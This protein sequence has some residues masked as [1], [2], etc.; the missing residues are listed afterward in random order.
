[1]A[2]EVATPAGYD[3]ATNGLDPAVYGT[4][5]SPAFTGTP[6]R[7]FPFTLDP[8]QAAACACIERGESVLVAAHTSA[9]KTAVAEYAIAAALRAGRTVAYTSPLKALSNQ[10]YRE[11]SEAFGEVGLL[12][13]DVTLAPAAPVTVMT[14]EILRSMLYRGSDGLD[15]LAWIVFDEVHYMQDRER[16][17]VWEEAIIF[18]P[19][20][21]RMV[22]LS[23]T[24]SNA[25][26]FAGWV[27]RLRQA[28]C[29]VIS[30]DTRPTPLQHYAYPLGGRGL[31]L[32]GDE[33]G[34]F[35]ADA[36]A[37]MRADAFG[38]TSEAEAGGGEEKE[39][40][41][42]A[43]RK[44]RK[45]RREAS[46]AGGVGGEAGG[47]PAQP[48]PP[49][50]QKL[51][52]GRPGAAAEVAPNVA[53]IVRLIHDRGLAPAIVFSFS[54]RNCE[55]YAAALLARRGGDR[56]PLPPGKSAPPPDPT[57]EPPAFNTPAESAAVDVVFDQAIAC[58]SPADAGLRAVTALRPLLRAGV[59]VHHSGLLP[60]LKE[61]VELL[62][63]EG[64]VKVLFATETFAMGLNMPAKTVVFTEVSGGGRG[65]ER[66]GAAPLFPFHLSF[67][68]P[69]LCSTLS[70]RSPPPSLSHQARKWDGECTRLMTSGEYIQ[71]S[72]RAGRRGKDDRGVC[73][74]LADSGLGAAAAAAMLRGGGGPLQSSFRL[75]FYTLLNLARRAEGSGRDAEYVVARSFRQYQHEVAQPLLAADKEAVERERARVVAGVVGEGT[76]APAAAVALALEAAALRRTLRDALLAPHRVAALLT[77]GRL[78]RVR[79]GAADWGWGLVVSVSREAGGPAPPGAAGAP[80]GA[81]PPATPLPPDPASAFTVD[82]LL[83]CAPGSANTGAPPSPASPGDPAAELHAVPVP[84]P[85]VE[86]AG[87]LRVGLPADLRPPA[88]R[89]AALATLACLEA[90]YAATPGGIPTLDPVADAGVDDP[91]VLQAAARLREVEARLRAAAAG[92]ASLA[93]ALAGPALASS[94]AR[95]A[96]LASRSA[97]LT[98]AMRDS[99]LKL[100][101]AEARR[102]LGVLRA[103]GHLEASGE[104]EEEGGGGGGGPPALS[105][106]LTLKGRAA[107]EIDAADELLAAE[108]MFN[109]VF[110]GL[111][112]PRLA[113]LASCLVPV[114]KSTAPVELAAALAGPLADLQAA[115]RRIGSAQVDARIP[116]A[117]APD[118]YVAGF[119]PT[120]MDAV[121]AWA[122][123]ATF[124]QVSEDGGGG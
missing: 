35:R 23:A 8:F 18:A 85:L 72:G 58:L 61:L 15:D 111:D 17:V 11:L 79:D 89:A 64:L 1:M 84:L 114:E 51:A 92:D 25:S 50:Q 38:I 41:G 54:R 3:D 71:M 101:R 31:Y 80:P 112:P 26:E 120:L 47:S 46:P 48:A 99:Q 4:L 10:K 75:S 90:R 95:A 36:W 74:L 44:G 102:R 14:T 67:T 76:G 97:A 73:I 29:H 32:V 65:N 83:R 43:D 124:Q 16:G 78:V 100:Y 57:S 49:Q 77:P 39:E 66:A 6:A 82:T 30:T 2:H 68:N 121:Y 62:F 37:K 45:R 40:E 88:P 116:D 56:R 7:T 52:P 123:G 105:A 22:F 28:P 34:G 27:A 96:A 13:G 42:P 115:A 107:C 93:A 53:R 122:R 70:L 87:A 59:G 86:A 118:D 119:A 91:P 5:A 24:L 104:G 69:L 110:G 113:A 117:P 103:L 63:A 108:L 55:A 60:I 109:G 94:A 20:G 19:P 12:T 98:A 9:G 81:A 33:A 106:V 21:V